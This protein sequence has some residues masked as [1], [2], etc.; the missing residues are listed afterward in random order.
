MATVRRSSNRTSY[1][2]CVTVEYTNTYIA[3][4]P[5]VTSGGVYYLRNLYSGYYLDVEQSNTGNGSRV[6]QWPYQGG[7]N[8]QYKI[9][10][11]GITGYYRLVPMHAQSKCVLLSTSNQVVLS[12]DCTSDRALWRIKCEQSGGYSLINRYDEMNHSYT[13]GPG[14]TGCAQGDLM[15]GQNYST[16]A[17]YRWLLEAMPTGPMTSITINGTTISVIGSDIETDNPVSAATFTGLRIIGN[18]K[19][20]EHSVKQ[21]NQI[22]L[23]LKELAPYLCTYTQGY[24]QFSADDMSAPYF[25]SVQHIDVAGKP[26]YEH[27]YLRSELLYCS[28]C[29]S[30]PN[31][32]RFLIPLDTFIT[33]LGYFNKWCRITYKNGAEEVFIKGHGIFVY[34]GS[35]G[36]LSEVILENIDNA[37]SIG[38]GFVPIVGEVKDTV[39]AVA[40]KDFITGENLAG[41]ERMVSA[42]CVALPVVGGTLINDT[43]KGVSKFDNILD[44]ADGLSDAARAKMRADAWDAMDLFTRGEF[45]EDDYARNFLKQSDGWWNIGKEMGGKYPGI[46]FITSFTDSSNTRVISLKSLDLKNCYKTASGDPN[47]SSIKSVINKYAKSLSDN[48]YFINYSTTSIPNIQKELRIVVP[49]G[50]ESTI[51]SLTG[52]HLRGINLVVEGY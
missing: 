29:G 13:M 45:I 1:Q 7:T 49:K 10:R 11:D 34:Q 40:G 44:T 28:E 27:T 41:W 9:T 37:I 21:G 5:G 8:Q 24:P 48:Q 51:T 32:N 42:I 19:L 43:V 16:H 39:E 22:Y 14:G 17:R 35:D 18:G 15:T 50:M 47:L 3:S 36:T 23:C 12:D 33:D 38:L 2:P 52:L 4:A 46:D 6:L 30:H 31:A 26:T 20:L 25:V